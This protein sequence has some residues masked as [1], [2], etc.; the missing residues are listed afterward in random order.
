LNFLDTGFNEETYNLEGAWLND[1]YNVY[2]A[3]SIGRPDDTS[4]NRDKG[5]TVTGSIM[6]TDTI[7]AG[8]SYY[9]GTNDFATRHVMGPW[10]IIGI[11]SRSYVL[12][13]G[14]FQRLY[15]YNFSKPQ[16]GFADYVRADFEAVQGLHFFGTQEI[17]HTNFS[18]LNTLKN[19][20]GAGTQWFPRPH[21]EIEFM[22]QTEQNR[23]IDSS[24]RQLLWLMLHFYL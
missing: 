2:A 1:T 13:E 23:A 9:Y 15:G 8:A 12:A 22:W 17:L 16:W 21:Y 10:G 7:K 14:D 11:S 6:A 20:F 18:A 3:G 4:L 5:A 24:Y 19:R